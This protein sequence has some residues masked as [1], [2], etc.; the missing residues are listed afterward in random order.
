MYKLLP[1][2]LY[3]FGLAVYAADDPIDIIYPSDEIYDNSYA[4]I[5]GIDKYENVQNL[6]YA[7]KDAES[8]QDILVNTFDFPEDN[9]RLLKNEEA[10]KDAILKAFSDLT[11]KA[12]SNDRVLIYFA[13]HGETL[14][15]TEG[16]ERGY[17]LPVDGDKEDLYL[18][19]IG[20]DELEKISEMSKA[21]H[22][23]YLV[24]ACYSG[25]ACAFRKPYP[26]QN[27]HQNIEFTKFLRS[28]NAYNL[29]K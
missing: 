21:K 2:L 25:I 19:S 26:L 8:I 12:E 3:T 24:D 15:L 23:L 1:I 7:V 27:L 5:I 17:L 4:L 16:G 28:Q 9:V 13:G 20:M 22:M 11:K 29:P 6:N 18:S 10:N 14:D